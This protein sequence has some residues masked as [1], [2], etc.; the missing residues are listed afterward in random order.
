MRERGGYLC[1]INE[2]HLATLPRKDGISENVL[3]GKNCL[4]LVFIKN[5]REK[6]G[7][8]SLQREGRNSGGGRQGRRTRLA[9][10]VVSE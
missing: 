2:V 7:F 4:T 8:L 10:R 1:S 9:E 3:R 6:E 5:Y